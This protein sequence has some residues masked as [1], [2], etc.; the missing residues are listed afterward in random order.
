MDLPKL[1]PPRLPGETK[2][3]AS[4]STAR[5]SSRS[6]LRTSAS[7]PSPSF[8]RPSFFSSADPPLPSPSPAH[9]PSRPSSSIAIF[10]EIVEAYQARSVHIFFTHL[11]PQQFALFEAAGLVDLLGRG[12][13]QDDV[14]SAIRIVEEQGLGSSVA[15][16]E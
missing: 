8:P 1:I 10:I 7:S 3:T 14:M 9:P 2:P 12:Y 11:R 16:R 6:I 15:V 5:T 13:F 4:S